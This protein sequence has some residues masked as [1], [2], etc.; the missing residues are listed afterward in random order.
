MPRATPPDTLDTLT[1]GRI[2]RH[3]L[4]H[5]RSW[6]TR[7]QCRLIVALWRR[8]FVT[9]D[10]IDRILP[11]RDPFILALNHS[12]KLE[13]LIVP[14]FLIY[15]RSGRLIHFFADWPFLLVPFVAAAFR[16]SQVIVVPNKSA[17]YRVLNRLRPALVPDLPPFDQASRYLERGEPVGIF[18]EGTVNRSPD[19]LLDGRIGAARLSLETGVPIVPAGIRFPEH[20][21]EGPIDERARLA[22]HIGEPVNPEVRGRS[23]R[24]PRD[25]AQLL[26]VRLMTAIAALSGKRWKDTGG[27]NQ[28]R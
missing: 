26:H 18:P 23:D 25:E 24:V 13:A 11:G 21:G 8:R 16:R 22:I 9:V 17:R 20:D 19:R 28:C 2:W 6:R 1:P 15:L 4:P 27:G 7:L 3:P 14:T 10:G 12:Q 5:L